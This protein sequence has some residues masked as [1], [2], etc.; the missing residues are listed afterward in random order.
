MTTVAFRDGVMA[1]DSRAVDSH[2]ITVSKKI[3][4]K[5][6][7]KKEHLVGVC[8]DLIAAMLFVDWY[9]S[10]D[11]KILAALR[12][13]G[14]DADFHVLVWTGSKLF[15]ANSLCRL[16]EV[17]EAFYS[18]GSGAAHAMTAMDCGKSA[19]QAVALAARRDPNTGGRTVTAT[20]ESKVKKVVT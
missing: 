9:G 13:A 7:G 14:V 10:G 17:E 3:F 6:V 2:G 18:V 19:A 11:D 1:S 12:A 5:K 4:R 16:V 20:L 8:G 15:T